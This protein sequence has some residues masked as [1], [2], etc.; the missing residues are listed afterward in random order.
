MFVGSLYGYCTNRDV[1]MIMVDE[2]IYLGCA[3]SIEMM[4]C[5]HCQL[6]GILSEILRSFSMQKDLSWSSFFEGA[7]RWL[8]AFK[9]V[10]G[11]SLS[12]LFSC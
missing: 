11:C 6:D 12:P 8:V 3:C 7:S 9:D 2:E 1:C 10:R 5:W 4:K